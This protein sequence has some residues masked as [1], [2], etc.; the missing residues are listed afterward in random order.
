M[1]ALSKPKATDGQ[2][3]FPLRRVDG[4]GRSKR[5]SS[6]SDREQAKKQKSTPAPDQQASQAK[7]SVAETRVIVNLD[8]DATGAESEA[9]GTDIPAPPPVITK[10]EKVIPVS[11]EVP[12]FSTILSGSAGPTAF[13]PASVSDFIE[14]P[15]VRIPEEVSDELLDFPI[16]NASE[17]WCPSFTVNRG[18]SVYADDPSSGG[19]LGWRMLKDLPTPADR[20]TGCFVAPCGQMMNDILRTVNFAVG[21]VHMYRH[22]QRQADRAEVVLKKADE[23]RQAHKAEIDG[24]KSKISKLE[25]KVIDHNTLLK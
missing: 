13:V 14:F 5:A 3:I 7:D 6:A 1:T 20:P 10:A 25:E 16:G 8:E 18:E 24:Y 22:Y 19:S 9:Y 23:E 15:H 12:R 11:R 21:V 2:F 4:A 17:P